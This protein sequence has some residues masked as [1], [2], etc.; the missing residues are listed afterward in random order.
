MKKTIK[1]KAIRLIICIFLA[2]CLAG[3]HNPES[4]P[5][6]TEI[7]IEE[8]VNNFK[9]MSICDFNGEIRYVAFETDSLFLKATALTAFNKDYILVSDR[10]IC[11]LY[12][13]AGNFISRIGRQ[14]KGPGEYPYIVKV[15][16]GMDNN[17][18][19]NDGSFF[20]VFDLSGNF[21]YKFKPEANPEDAGSGNYVSSF[22]PCNDSIFIGQIRNDSGL[23]KYKAVFFDSLGRTVKWVENYIIINK[24]KP[25]THSANG[26]ANIYRNGG[27]I[28]IKEQ[29]N[30]T[31]FRINGHY[32]FEPA[33]YLNLGKYGVPKEVR[34]L[35]M[36]EGIKRSMDYMDVYR[37]FETANFLFLGCAF[38]NHHPIMDRE[39]FHLPCTRPNWAWALLGAYDKRVN[40]LAFAKLNTT[41]TFLTISGLANDYDGGISFFPKDQ[42]NESTLSMWVDVYLLKEHIASDYFKKSTPKYPE[43]KKELEAFVNRLNENDNPVLILY[44][45]K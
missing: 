4:G 5:G 18:Y 36:S 43:K 19:I 7:N 41:G 2:A 27:A 6:L 28:Y 8:N 13:R 11:L 17:I 14:G 21:L 26:E 32:Q 16:I 3:C 23:E 40:K 20:S 39:N 34:E 35:R 30:D 25:Y 9:P 31:V 38:N 45:F 1:G 44:S 42:V 15:Q 33:F 10:S 37:V 29:L 22:A 12:G 24:I